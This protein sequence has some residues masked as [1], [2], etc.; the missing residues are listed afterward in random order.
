M[1]GIEGKY[2][3]TVTDIR[4]LLGCSHDKARTIFNSA[5]KVELES[6]LILAHD[7]KVAMK[8]VVKLTGFDVNFYLKLNN[9]KKE[10]SNGSQKIT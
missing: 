7:N 10:G 8:T 6:G 2:Y 4:K 5:R 3:I 1:N 9:Q